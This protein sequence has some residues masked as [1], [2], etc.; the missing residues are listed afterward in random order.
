LMGRLANLPY[1]NRRGDSV[2]MSCGRSSRGPQTRCAGRS[3][4]CPR[5]W[6]CTARRNRSRSSIRP[7]HFLRIR[8]TTALP[9]LHRCPAR[10]WSARW[11]PWRRCARG[12]STKQPHPTKRYGLTERVQR[13]KLVFPAVLVLQDLLALYHPDWLQ[14]RQRD[15]HS[16]TVL[17]IDSH[18]VGLNDGSS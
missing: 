6:P 10:G 16:L 7:C 9:R 18:V 13:R 3:R 14:C 4:R 2:C 17:L 15:P 11:M 8:C 1:S 5:H 12:S